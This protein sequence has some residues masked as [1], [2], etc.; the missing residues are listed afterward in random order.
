MT[1]AK[2]REIP[3][4]IRASDELGREE[5]SQ[6]GARKALRKRE[7]GPVGHARMTVFRPPDN[8]SEISVNRMG[9]AS[10]AEMADIGIRNAAADGGRSFWGW[11]MLSPGD[12]GAAR[13][14]V[15]PSPTC[16]NPYHAD[17]VM[18]VAPDAEDRRDALT[19]YAKDLA[20]R[21]VFRPW[22]EWVDQ[23]G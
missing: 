6:T 18:P 2:S 12:I 3:N 9:F 20:D 14:S 21:A 11:Y 1:G 7:K 10:G 4:A 8:A 5:R 16:D 13:C 17:I 23:S 15:E 22:G 19:D